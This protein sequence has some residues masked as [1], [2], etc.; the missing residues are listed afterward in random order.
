MLTDKAPAPEKATR[1]AI[2]ESSQFDPLMALWRFFTNTKVAVVLILLTLVAAF[3]GTH[4]PQ[5]PSW[6][7]AS[8]QSYAQWLEK[9][10]IG[11][12][13]LTDLL[14]AIGLFDAYNSIWF[15]AL[16]SLL[17]I[18]TVT[19]T[20]N[21]IPGIWRSVFQFKVIMGDGFYANSTNRAF[22]SGPLALDKVAGVLRKERY[23]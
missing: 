13:S 16:C 2:D 23:Q 15:R 21:R 12:G 20:A 4:F 18:N 3:I 22:L 5:A 8:P 9:V 17:I 10:R 7:H 19:C 1:P 11:F 6:A 14:S